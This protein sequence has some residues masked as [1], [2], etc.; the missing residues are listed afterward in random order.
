MPV[1][2]VGAPGRHAPAL[3]RPLRSGPYI[4]SLDVEFHVLGTIET[5]ALRLR[6]VPVSLR[7]EGGG[8]DKLSVAALRPDTRS[9]EAHSAGLDIFVVEQRFVTG[10][11][12]TQNGSVG[13]LL[14]R[15][16]AG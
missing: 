16:Q 15:L 14:E 1:L 8:G 10:L 9:D 13:G 11:P 12:D 5:R 4:R 6:R 7:V 3:S 2:V